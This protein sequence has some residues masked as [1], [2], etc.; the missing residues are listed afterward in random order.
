MADMLLS[1][2]EAAFLVQPD[3]SS[4]GRCLQAAL[5]TLL[6]QDHV[7]F[8]EKTS[9]FSDRILHL[10]PGG[11]RPLPPHIATV[12]T[13]LSSYKPGSSSLKRSQVVH[14][15]QKGFGMGF[16]RYVHDHL[17]PSLIERGLLI[18]HKRKFLGLIPYTRY[19]RT[20]RGYAVAAPLKRLVA[21]I[22]DLETWVAADPGRAMAMARSAGILLVM[23]PKAFRQ[24]PK[25]RTLVQARGNDAPTASYTY[26]SSD[27]ESDHE[28][29]AAISDM[30]LTDDVLDLVNS[31]TAAAD[32]TS[33]GGGG[34]SD[35]GDGG[36]GGD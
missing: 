17:A 36:G 2:A 34:D 35:G 26:S 20:T 18:R 19:E 8:G 29:A 5:L 33:A 27:S 6:G 24:I 1:P 10:R 14:A 12:K 21:E 31:V 13:A 16:G 32:F 9:F 22:D 28:A 15:L 30:R 7:E 25:L 11:G 4:A 3:S 23:S